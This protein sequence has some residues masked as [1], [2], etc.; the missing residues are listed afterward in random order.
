MRESHYVFNNARRAGQQER[1]PTRPCIVVGQE[2]APRPEES[3]SGVP[4]LAGHPRNSA[5]FLAHYASM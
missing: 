4:A 5:A 2:A 3:K 1:R